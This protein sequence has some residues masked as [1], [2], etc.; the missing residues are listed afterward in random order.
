MTRCLNE[1]R[2][3]VASH[4]PNKVG[5]IRDLFAAMPIAVISAAELGLPEPEE[6]GATFAENA[7]LKAV[8][9]ATVG[10]APALADDSGLSVDALGGDPGIYS[11]RWAGPER[12]FALAM[13][14]VED[15]LRAAGASRPERRRASFVAALC[16]AW[17]DGA[18]AEVVGE[19]TGTLVWP[20][21]GDRGFGYD[22]MFQ[23]NGHERTFGGMTAEEKR[24]SPEEPLS[25][26]A[27]ALKLLTER[28]LR[29]PAP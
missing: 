22:P 28:V 18:L 8:T 5:E 13:W 11:A 12:D 19:V 14:R 26:R 15:A 2:L 21:R 17:P 6:T 29:S 24:G 25:H 3:I 7:R 23:P 10:G 27:R 9:A 20:P 1:D 4:N 16:L